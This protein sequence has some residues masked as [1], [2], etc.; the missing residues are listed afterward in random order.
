M[1]VCV[2]TCIH[3]CLCVRLED[4]LGVTSENLSDSFETASVIGLEL[5]N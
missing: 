2:Y 3:T 1:C 4:N 5:T